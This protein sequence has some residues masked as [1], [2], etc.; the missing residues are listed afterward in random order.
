M[1]QT[2]TEQTAAGCDAER[3]GTVD[4]RADT[5]FSQHNAPR[6]GWR[7]SLNLHRGVVV[8]VGWL[9]NVLATCECIS[10]VDL[11]GQFYV[12]PH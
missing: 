3:R 12:L 6:Q 10:E 2:D 11:P 5:F 8:V 1:T 4:E 7:A 9:L